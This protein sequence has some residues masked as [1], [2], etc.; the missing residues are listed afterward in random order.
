MNN[1]PFERTVCACANCVSCCKRQSGPL[2]PSDFDP[3]R[4]FLAEV[5]PLEKLESYLVA[6]RGSL[7]MDTRTG[8]TGWIGSITPRMIE[9]D[10][11]GRRCVFLDENDRCRIHAVSPAGC[12]LL[13]THMNIIDGQKRG[14]WVAM[15]MDTP[16]YQALRS[17]LPVNPNPKSVRCF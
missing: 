3:I 8:K 14:V 5:E 15:Q 6:S 7:M 10:E 9:G 17:T 16:E 2:V 11:R 1:P 4:K 12:R 13:D